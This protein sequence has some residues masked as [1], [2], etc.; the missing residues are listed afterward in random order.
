VF[1][2]Y[3]TL[4]VNVTLAVI[5]TRFDKSIITICT[6][7]NHVLSLLHD[8]WGMLPNVLLAVLRLP[9][10]INEQKWFRSL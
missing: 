2:T 6:T 8:K 5:I 7:C 1:T 9:I 4:S 3:T 10:H